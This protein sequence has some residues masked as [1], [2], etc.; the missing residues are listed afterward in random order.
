MPTVAPP[1][2][3]VGSVV[4]SLRVMQA[5]APTDRVLGVSELARRL[6]IGKSTVY[7]SLQTLAGEGFVTQTP[8]AAIGWASSCGN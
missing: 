6:G 5:V 2:K 8:A 7:R 1:D 4:T 3:T